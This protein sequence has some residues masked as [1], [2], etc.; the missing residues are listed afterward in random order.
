[1]YRYREKREHKRIEKP[2]M[3]RL[4][5]KQYEGLEISSAE[6]DIVALKDLSAGGALFYYSKYLGLGSLLDLKIDVSTAT[7]TVRCAGKVTRIEQSLAHSLIRIATEFT[8][9]D[10]HVKEMMNTTI[11][12]ALEQ[13]NK[14]SVS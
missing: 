1:M 4:R 9:I 10:E 8:E 6:W 14:T 13:A 2:Y 12:K 7:P 11:E 3:A 5:I